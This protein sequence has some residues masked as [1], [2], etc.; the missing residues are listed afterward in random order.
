MIELL[1]ILWERGRDAASPAPVSSSQ[2]RVLYILERDEGINLRNLGRL[3]GAAP[4]SVSRLCDRLQAVGFVERTTSPTSRR[5]VELWLTPSGRRFLAELRA[6]REA[7]L[8]SAISAMSPPARKALTEGLSG[9][10]AAVRKTTDIGGERPGDQ[11][12]RSA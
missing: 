2:L 11:S 7:A 8:R 1:E 10:R 3:L 5:E 9:F 6:R 12:A 4:S